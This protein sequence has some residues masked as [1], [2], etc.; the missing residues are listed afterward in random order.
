MNT[1]SRF[2]VAIHILTLLASQPDTILTS[3]EIACSVT[4]NPVVIRRVLGRLRQAGLVRSQAGLGGGW[5]LERLPEQITLQDA[6]CAMREG[7]LFS[8][9]LPAAECGLLHRQNGTARSCFVLRGGR[10]RAGTGVRAD[11]AG[12]RAGLRTARLTFLF[13]SRKGNFTRKNVTKAVYV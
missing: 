11:D 5:Q 12:G 7:N 8:V 6:Y 9:S 3:G 4:T 10:T 2:A 13:A 1:N